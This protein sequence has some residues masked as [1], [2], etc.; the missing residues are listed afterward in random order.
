[1]AIEADELKVHAADGRVLSVLVAGPPATA[2]VFFLHGTPGIRDLPGSDVEEGARR[3]LRH[4]LYARPGYAGSDRLPGRK[5]AD[6][7]ADIEAIADELEIDDFYVA[8]ESG[9]GSHALACAALLP[10][11]VRGVATLAGLAPSIAED[12]DWEEGMG[13]GNRRE[14]GEMWKGVEALRRYLES[15]VRGLRSI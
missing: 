2:H 11:R 7:A 3:G 6:C 1:M 10:G 9:G 12:L 8:G 5:V 15:E 13:A 4:V 14:F